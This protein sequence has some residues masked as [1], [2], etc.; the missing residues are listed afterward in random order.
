MS[1]QSRVNLLKGK[2][3]RLDRSTVTPDNEHYCAAFF[4]SPPWYEAKEGMEEE[5]LATLMMLPA[6]YLETKPACWV[7]L[8]LARRTESVRVLRDVNNFLLAVQLPAG[9]LERDAKWVFNPFNINTH[10]DNLRSK[11]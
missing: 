11:S 6:L 9:W 2:L 5:I 1:K 8:A 3:R 7:Y 10:L 4:T